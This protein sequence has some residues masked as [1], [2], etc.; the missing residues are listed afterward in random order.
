M[1]RVAKWVAPDDLRQLSR[2][3]ITPAWLNPAPAKW[4]R[5]SAH[6]YKKFLVRL[7]YVL[8]AVGLDNIKP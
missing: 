3:R 5:R 6:N 8:R 7:L 2:S 1:N 4:R